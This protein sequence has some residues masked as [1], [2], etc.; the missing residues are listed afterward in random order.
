MAEIQPIPFPLTDNLALIYDKLPK[1]PQMTP[2]ERLQYD[3]DRYNASVGKLTGY[4]CPKCKNRGYFMVAIEYS[5]LK[6]TA[7]QE[8]SCMKTRRS[9]R[10]IE[11]SGLAHLLDK[12][13]FETFRTGMPWQRNA[14]S[15][16]QKYL[17]NYR[18]NW[19][20][21]GGQVGSGK[22]HICTAIV[23]KLL[24]HGMA[25]KYMLWRDEALTLKA[26]VNNDAAYE[27]AISPLK[28]I[29]VLYIDDF[30]KT[31]PDK[32]P[33]TGDLN[34]AFELLN[35]RY[36]NDAITIISSE[37][38]MD[39]IMGIDEAIGSRIFQKAKNYCLNIAHDPKKN[40]RMSRGE[41]KNEV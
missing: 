12:C 15:M 27:E 23:G 32:P 10:N 5:A 34:V 24:D 17:E 7:L 8:C 41:Q 40:Y 36:N 35:Y 14:L 2:E 19:L 26:L 21:A 37:Y 4:N 18:G 28:R 11:N 38:S 20:Y 6:S 29:D 31:P 13:T 39:D 22:T 1:I 25:A 9:L 30:L 33:T 3:I 16:A